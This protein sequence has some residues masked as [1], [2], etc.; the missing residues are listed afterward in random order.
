ME[1][2]AINGEFAQPNITLTSG[3]VLMSRYRG[4]RLCLVNA[5]TYT[6]YTNGEL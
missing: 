2:Y 5:C 4:R 1:V 3:Y 6:L